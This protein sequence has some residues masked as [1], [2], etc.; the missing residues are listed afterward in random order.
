MCHAQGPQC[1]DACEARI[2][3]PS[4]SSLELYHCFFKK[5][6]GNRDTP[7]VYMLCV[8]ITCRVQVLP[9]A[10]VFLLLYTR[11]IGQILLLLSHL[12]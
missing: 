7:A 4:V 12:N 6:K 9:A 1:S 5:N 2:C 8:E 3:G 11:G 10:A